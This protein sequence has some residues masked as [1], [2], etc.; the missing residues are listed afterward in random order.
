VTADQYPYN[1]SSTSIMAML[2]PDAEREGGEQATARRL[3][4]PDEVARLRPIVAEALS[5]RGQLMIASCK[6]KPEW[7]GKMIGEVAKAEG[8][9]PVEIGLEL[10]R[11]GRAQG[12]NFGMDE[13]DVR[14]VM[15]LPWVATA[16]D[17]SS[18]I[19]DGKRPHPR[20]YGTFARK[21]GRYGI[22]EKVIPLPTAVRSATG[23]PADILGMSD[24]GYLR[25]GM[26]ADVAVIDPNRYLDQA[27]YEEPFEPS[28]GVQWLLVNGQV[29]IADG[30]LQQALAGRPLRRE[31]PARLKV[32]A[33]KNDDTRITN[34]N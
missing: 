3:Q 26:A 28:T 8:R 29:A 5:S 10:L 18:K 22:K 7:I 21:I 27:T 14:Y 6:S 20:S 12:V 9:E 1:A 25:K 24:R 16:S 4:D 31:L 23:L 32:D 17:G 30:K 13:V 2:L 19:D 11:D 15:T 33:R 34:A